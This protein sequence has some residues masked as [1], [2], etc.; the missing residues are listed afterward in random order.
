[1]ATGGDDKKV[2]VWRVGGLSPIYSLTGNSTA[3][4]QL[5]FDPHETYLVSGSQVFCSAATW[6]GL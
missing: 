6:F 2:N 3:V 5:R 1:M 4:E